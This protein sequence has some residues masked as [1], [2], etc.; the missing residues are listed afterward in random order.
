MDY[1]SSHVYLYANSDDEVISDTEYNE[2][3]WLRYVHSVKIFSIFPPDT[4]LVYVEGGF[5]LPQK[6]KCILVIVDYLST[7]FRCSSVHIQ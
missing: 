2:G 7:A 3:M 5:L 1:G 4:N 6:M